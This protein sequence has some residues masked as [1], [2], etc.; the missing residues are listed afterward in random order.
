MVLF[1]PGTVDNEARGVVF[2]S[3]PAPKNTLYQNSLIALPHP[4][5]DAPPCGDATC[6]GPRGTSA[7]GGSAS[8]VRTVCRPVVQMLT[9]SA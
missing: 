4:A 5:L 3:Y 7:R 6:G 8:Q 2:V 1:G 9:P